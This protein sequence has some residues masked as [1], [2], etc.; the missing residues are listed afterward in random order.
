MTLQNKIIILDDVLTRDEC[1]STIDYYKKN[2]P[3]GQ[4]HT[5]F[6][7]EIF[8]AEYNL[9]PA[10]DK[11]FGS[12]VAQLNIDLSIDWCEIVHWP[13]GAQQ[14]LHY[15]IASFDTVFTSAERLFL[16]MT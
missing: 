14:D 10:I 15:D 8:P 9:L 11:I 4:W 13:Q 6:P 2:G 3:T 12:V 1:A 7:R 5:F 16:K